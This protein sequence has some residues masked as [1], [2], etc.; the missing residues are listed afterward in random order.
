[1]RDIKASYNHLLKLK[2]KQETVIKKLEKENVLS[3]ELRENI[4]AVRSSEELEHLVFIFGYNV[5]Y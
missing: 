4:L 5:L 3:D 2:D 1:M